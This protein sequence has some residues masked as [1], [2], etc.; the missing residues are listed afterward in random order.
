MAVVSVSLADDMVQQ[1]DHA[2]A[3]EQAGRSAYV[4]AAIRA[5]LQDARL[6]GHAHGSITVAYGH[7]EEAR[8][9]EVRHA[10][11]DVVLSMM[12]THCDPG[13]CM[14]VLLVGGD[15][16]RIQRLHQTLEQMRAIDRAVLVI[17][18]SRVGDEDAAAP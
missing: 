14:D 11:H 17:L 5:R 9:S 1:M 15:A 16:E 3:Q 6:E 10:Y 12:H 8:V 4:R 2:A 7:G 18:P 13:Q